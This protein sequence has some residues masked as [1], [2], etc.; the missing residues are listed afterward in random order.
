MR[1]CGGSK[2]SSHINRSTIFYYVGIADAKAF[3]LNKN[4]RGFC[5]PLEKSF[6][7]YF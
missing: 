6:A 7:C 4:Y 1:F 3:S 2:P 5:L